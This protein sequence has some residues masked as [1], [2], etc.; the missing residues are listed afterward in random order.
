MGKIWQFAALLG[1][2]AVHAQQ[3]PYYFPP[4]TSEPVRF[5]IS[6]DRDLI[7]EAANKA[8]T[9]RSSL[10]LED[11]TNVSWLEGPPSAN[12]TA[13]SSYWA[14]TYNRTDTEATSM[15]VSPTMRSLSTLAQTI[16]VRY[17]CTLSMK[18]RTMRMPF[19]SSSSMAGHLHISNGLT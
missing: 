14:E 2:I 16:A 3:A 19:H 4:N 1:S 9:Y 8:K 12:M 7:R 5:N 13:L 17:L 11:E 18:D 6:V 15:S 10:D